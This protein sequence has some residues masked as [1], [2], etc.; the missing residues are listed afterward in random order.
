MSDLLNYVVHGLLIG[1]LYALV[2]MGFVVIYR[3]SKVFNF[4]QGE[5]IVL[6][7][8]LVWTAAEASLA[9]HWALA[10]AIAVSVAVGWAIERVFFSRLVGQSV[11]AMVMVTIGLI[12][13]LRGL[14]LIL[15]GAQERQFPAVFPVQP[16]IWGELIVPVPLVA[17]GLCAVLAAAALHWFFNRSRMGLALSAVSEDHEVAR[18]LGISVKRAI[19]TAW[20][21]GSALSVVGAAIFLS[22]KTLTFAASEIGFAALPV[23][24]LAGLES[25]GGLLL[26][27]AMI[28]LVQSLAGGYL[29]PLIGGHTAGAIPYVFMLAVLFVRP[30][31]LFGWTHIERV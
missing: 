28:G 1:E 25:V 10:V 26:A 27:G 9:P 20:M 7:G 30:T 12:I 5:L 22:G 15:W 3:A 24:L 17:G 8:F 31:G 21:L 16:I 18:S 19:S 14:M 2:A 6:G 11:F 13:L 23:A 4:A 29:D